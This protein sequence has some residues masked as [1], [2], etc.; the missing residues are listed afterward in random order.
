METPC[1]A[2]WAVWPGKPVFDEKRNRAILPYGLIYAE[3]G[4][5]NF[6]GVGESFGI[7]TDFTL[8]PERPVIDSAQEHP[9]LLFQEAEVGYG[10]APNIKDDRLYSFAC[11]GEG[12]VKPCTLGRVLLDA[13]LDH[14]AWEYWNGDA[15]SSKASEAEALFDGANIMG[16]DWNTHLGRFTAIYSSPGANDVVVRTAPELWGPWSEPATLFT[17][18]RKTTEGWVYDAMPHP[19]FSEADGAGLY[20]SF[21]RPTGVGWFG[22]EMAVERVELQ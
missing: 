16:V 22:A 7:W 19:E 13:L 20:L 11:E 18:D 4:D 1:G 12:F 15:W 6:H 17:A 3:P 2:R 5:F 10:I 8:A 14:S 21:S 9:T